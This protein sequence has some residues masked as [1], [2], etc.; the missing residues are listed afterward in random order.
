[1]ILRNYFAEF[2]SLQTY[3]F[4]NDAVKFYVPKKSKGE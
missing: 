4:T 1:M 3:T 2:D